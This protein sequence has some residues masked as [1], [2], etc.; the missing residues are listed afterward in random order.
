MLRLLSS[1]FSAC[2]LLVPASGGSDHLNCYDWRHLIRSIVQSRTYQLSAAPNENN[3]EVR[4]NYSRSQPRL[5][6]AAVLLDAIS[7]ATGIAEKFDYHAMTGGGAPAPG[8]RA[9][10]TLPDLMYV[11]IH[12]RLRTVHAQDSRAR[13]KATEFESGAAYA[14]WLHLLTSIT[15]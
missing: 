11:A 6:E 13:R 3:K 14:G 9:M 12:G 15:S 10:Q 4:I 5:L 7:A 8:A 1:T 2:Q